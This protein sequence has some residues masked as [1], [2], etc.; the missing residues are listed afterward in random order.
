MGTMRIRPAEDVDIA[1]IA[2]LYVENWK[3]T[4]KGIL[5]QGYLDSLSVEEKMKSWDDYITEPRQ[6]I[7]VACEGSLVLGFAAFKP[8][9]RVDDCIYLDSLHVK[10]SR[11]GQGIGSALIEAVYRRGREEQYG[12]M[13]VCVVKGNDDARNLYV[14]LGAEHY[15][16]KVDDFTGEISYSEIL[17]W[18]YHK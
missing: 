2:R 12:K 8:Y 14:K 3:E 9:H 7:F 16:D 11:R 13:G 17:L 18:N 6:G 10:K 5:P 15:R 1:Q 4:Y